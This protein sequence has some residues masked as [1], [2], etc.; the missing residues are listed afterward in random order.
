M[1][2]GR[3]VLCQYLPV[4]RI[5]LQQIASYGGSSPKQHA[6]VKNTLTTAAEVNMSSQVVSEQLAM[7]G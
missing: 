4:K 7:R 3:V 2:V 1:S 5:L 6:R